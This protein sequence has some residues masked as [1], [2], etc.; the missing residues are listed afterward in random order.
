MKRS[1]NIVNLALAAC[2]S[3]AVIVNGGCG[4]SEAAATNRGVYLSDQ[5]YVYPAQEIQIDALISK[6]DYNYP[7][8]VDMPVSLTAD[9][10]IRGNTGYIQIGMKGAQLG[11]EEFNRMNVC[12]VIDTSGSMSDRDKLS[13]VKNAFYIFINSVRDDD[14]ISV[15]E[16]NSD[17]KVL[18][19]PTVMKDDSDRAR[20]KRAVDALRPGGGTDIFKGVKLG[21]AQVFGNFDAA[22]INRVLLLTDGMHNQT[23]TTDDILDVVKRFNDMDINIS[24]IALGAEAD[25]EL[26]AEMAIAGGGSSR[27]ISDYDTM[28]RAFG[29]ELDRLIAPVARKLNMKLQLADG[30][31]LRETFGYRHWDDGNTVGYSLE[32]LHSGDYETLFAIVDFDKK[33]DIETK[34]ATF[35]MEYYLTNGERRVID[36]VDIYIDPRDLEDTTVIGNPRIKKAEGLVAY[37]KM[38]EEL[39]ELSNDAL[40]MQSTYERRRDAAT[41]DRL[42]GYLRDG[43]T[44]IQSMMTYLEDIN[45]YFETAVLADELTTL[46]NYADAY[47]ELY[48]KYA[49]TRMEPLRRLWR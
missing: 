45:A 47:V 10:D 26:M 29:S 5:G 15:V 35:T 41:R 46:G 4:A 48:N 17:A 7:A 34:I 21:F 20:F 1:M 39:D 24:T 30:V 22:I 13:W 40:D 25:I 42:V 31:R 14:I 38:L 49:P 6:E 37:G 18:L 3:F 2:L 27:F 44:M 33:P 28:E 32:T 9:A 23:G 43:I 19:P 12:F 8:P 36:P 11:F 16:Y